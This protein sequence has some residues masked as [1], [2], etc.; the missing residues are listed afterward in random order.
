M[1]SN[2]NS[3]VVLARQP[4]NR[5]C[6]PSDFCIEDGEIPYPDE[7][8]VLVRTGFLSLDPY[9]RTR[10][11]PTG[12]YV[13]HVEVGEVMVGEVIGEVIQS[14]HKEFSV[15]DVVLARSGWQQFAALPIED[16]SRVDT[17]VAPP[18]CYLGILGIPGM[19]AYYGLLEVA[20]PVKGETVLVPAA[21]GAVG[22]IVGQI[23][24]RCG[25]RV[26]GSTSSQVKADFVTAELGFDACI[27]YRG[28]NVD[29]LSAE[30]AE[31]CPQ[32]IDIYYDSVGG[33]LHD[34]AMLNIAINARIVIVGAI[35]RSSRMEQPD[36]GR[37]WT[38]ELLNKR[39]R[40]EGFLVLDYADRVNEFHQTMSAWM[41]DGTMSYREHIVDGIESAPKAFIDMLAGG[42]IGKQ[43][44]R[45]G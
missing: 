20:R 41:S 6:E 44:V 25:C 4:V 39:A 17:T 30:I 14:R 37:R 1:N 29:D 26:I 18:S 23:A 40:M 12:T 7:G 10:M 34:A 45:V 28:K 24:K 3:K 16:I 19:T 38:R 11:S 33:D 2:R 22:H 27:D 13:A 9:M 21:A 15:G 35:A 31:L 43:L 5:H 36:I 42:N 8:Q 32:G